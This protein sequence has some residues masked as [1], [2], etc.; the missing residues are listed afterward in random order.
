MLKF[1]MTFFEAHS[2]EKYGNVV[3]CYTLGIFTFVPL[4][5]LHSGILFFYSLPSIKV[6]CLVW[7]LVRFPKDRPSGL[8]S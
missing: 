2:A 1:L 4:Y 8:A 3:C 7:R 5:S 6:L